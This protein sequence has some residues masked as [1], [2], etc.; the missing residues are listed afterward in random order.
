[1]GN[2]WL[3]CIRTAVCGAVVGFIHD[4]PLLHFEILEVYNA[5]WYDSEKGSLECLVEYAPQA[6]GVFGFFAGASFH[7]GVQ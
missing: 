6:F 2:W 3:A 7:Y 5:S 4:W 1:M